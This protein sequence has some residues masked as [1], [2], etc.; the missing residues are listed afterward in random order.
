VLVG[1][2]LDEETHPKGQKVR[3]IGPSNLRCYLGG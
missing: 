2:S 1:P 3:G